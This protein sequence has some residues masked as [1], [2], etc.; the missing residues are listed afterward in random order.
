MIIVLPLEHEAI[1][2]ISIAM[3]KNIRMK[4]KVK[5]ILVTQSYCKFQF[6]S[7]SYYFVKLLRVVVLFSVPRD[8]GLLIPEKNN[9]LRKEIPRTDI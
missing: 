3:T 2:S 5:H 6:I 7:V 4:T 9:P 8:S 1:C